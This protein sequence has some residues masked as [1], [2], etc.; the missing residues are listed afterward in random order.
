MAV[1]PGARQQANVPQENSR[2]LDT[3]AV[4]SSHPWR[5]IEIAVP[6][7]RLHNMIYVILPRWAL[8]MAII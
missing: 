5:P 8:P 1:K 4:C 7:D 2:M 6:R 3:I